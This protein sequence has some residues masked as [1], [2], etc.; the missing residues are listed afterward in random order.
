MTIPASMPSS[1]GFSATCWSLVLNASGAGAGGDGALDELCRRYRHPVYAYLRH[2]GHQPQAARDITRTF[3][4]D[5]IAS[6]LAG[7]AHAR[8]QRFRDFLLQRLRGFLDA[9]WRE[10]PGTN[11]LA[12]APDVDELEARDQR[13]NP[14]EAAPVDAFQRSFAAEVMARALARLGDEARAAGHGAMYEAL[15]PHL[16]RDPSPAGYAALAAAL[17]QRPLALIVA[18]KR[19]RQRFRELV[20]RE[21]SDTVGSAA[22]LAD[23]QKTLHGFFSA[24]G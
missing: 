15:L 9:D 20:G 19:L 21:L 4:A 1:G 24:G 2:A 11:A 7:L 8:R 18:L 12:W 13:D 14:P 10:L 23:E 17:G 6:P 5:L 22:D 3:F 16:T